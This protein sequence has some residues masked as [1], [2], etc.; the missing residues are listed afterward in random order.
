M[1]RVNTAQIFPTFPIIND[2]FPPAHFL[3]G[4][5]AEPSGSARPADKRKISMKKGHYFDSTHVLSPL[6]KKRCFQR[7]GG[8]P[9][10][11]P[12]SSWL[13]LD[14]FSTLP[15]ILLT[16]PIGGGSFFFALFLGGYEPGPCAP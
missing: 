1:K 16:R 11:H 4:P 5:P 14:A 15:P 12:G 3:K 7:A 2:P 10:H 8:D 13:V 9:L 6:F